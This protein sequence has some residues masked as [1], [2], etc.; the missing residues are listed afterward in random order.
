[1]VERSHNWHSRCWRDVNVMSQH[2][3][4]HRACFR[5]AGQALLGVVDEVPDF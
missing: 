2:V 4:F 5:E 3:S 1:M